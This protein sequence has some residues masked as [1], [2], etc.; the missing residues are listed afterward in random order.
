LEDKV[1]RI[2]DEIGLKI[3]IMIST[4]MTPPNPVIM[5]I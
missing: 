1:V 4:G 5:K 3:Y 2:C